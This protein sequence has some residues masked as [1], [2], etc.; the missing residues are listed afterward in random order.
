MKEKN[1]NAQHI[2]D[3]KID[4]RIISLSSQ[5][6]RSGM[7]TGDFQGNR[8]CTFSYYDTIS[9]REVKLD[10]ADQGGNPLNKAYRMAFEQDGADGL[11][12]F[13]PAFIDVVDCKDGKGY[14]REEIDSFWQDEHYPVLFMTMV[15]I[16]E[17][18]DVEA[19]LKKVKSTFPAKCHLAYFTFDHSD[20]IL[21]YRGDSFEE[22]AGLIF[23]FNYKSGLAIYDTITLYSFCR[24]ARDYEADKSFRALIS[25]GVRDYHAAE[26]F[27]SEVE[28]LG[29]KIEKAWLLGRNDMSIYCEEAT[30]KWL[31]EVRS[32]A[33]N[34]RS[35]GWYTTYDLLIPIHPNSLEAT[36]VG[37][38]GDALDISK[39]KD[40]MKGKYRSFKRSYMD[41]Y[42]KLGLV[43]DKVWLRWLKESSELSADLLGNVLSGDLGVCLAPQFLGLFEYGIKFFNSKYFSGLESDETDY[44][45]RIAEDEK[46][47]NQLEK[48]DRS[49]ADFFSD[50]AILIDSM[51]QTNRQFVQVPSFHLPS[52]DVPPKIMAL[53]VAVGHRL[54]EVLHDDTGFKYELV[55]LPKYTRNLGILSL[56]AQDVLPGDQWLEVMISEPSFYSLQMTIETMGH[57]ISH[58]SGQKNRCRKK[59]GDLMIECALSLYLVDI[60]KILPSEAV[61]MYPSGQESMPRIST[62]GYP[63]SDI[64][65]SAKKLRRTAKEALPGMFEREPRRSRVI[66]SITYLLGEFI[67][68]QQLFGAL[69]EQLWRLECN[70]SSEVDTTIDYLRWHSRWEH[71]FGEKERLTPTEKEARTRLVE[72][73]FLKLVRHVVSGYEPSYRLSAYG[74]E[75]GV[76][77]DSNFLRLYDLFKKMSY[78]FSETFADLQ[79]ILLFEMDWHKYC[80]LMKREEDIKLTQD[81]P[82][83]MLAVAKTLVSERVWAAEDITDGGEEFVTTEDAV[84]M[85]IAENYVD[86]DKMGFNPI[87]LHYLFEY[88]KCCVG[89][90]ELFFRKPKIAGQVKK[91]RKLHAALSNETSILDLQKEIRTYV[92]SFRKEFVSSGKT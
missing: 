30:L 35:K 92:E 52:F 34:N 64:L 22:Y 47:R 63:L 3:R 48:I 16:G 74:I 6:I 55:L 80:S 9:V 88:L 67:V 89:V 49:F 46:R 53:Y 65:N 43:Y 84:K 71:G 81:C 79:M 1:N 33:L 58:F 40:R 50:M 82:L 27:Y 78:F 25:F 41:V 5:G 60:L 7:P 12:Q 10:S 66:E 76:P 38:G 20:L 11:S 15:N 85:D 18:E 62:G 42:E 26:N 23:P 19:V 51:N 39:I 28:G 4:A 86:L 77:P 45:K 36:K 2:S 69:K 13:I 21:F 83:R 14:T 44:G 29:K 59:R 73:K 24:V 75:V 31:S 68:Q 8:Y 72:N 61:S 91:L 54:K 32:R 17:A 57:E 87:L 70:G 37:L 90:I 56:A